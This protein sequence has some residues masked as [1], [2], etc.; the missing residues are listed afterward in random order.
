MIS[1]L[2]SLFSEKN[3]HKMNENDRYRSFFY[4][5]KVK[6]REKRNIEEVL[7]KQLSYE[8]L[9]LETLY[10]SVLCDIMEVRK[11]IS[12]QCEVYHG[13]D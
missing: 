2:H 11:P 6:L 13:N 9:I 3:P 10:N 1:L 4:Y 12:K 5:V 8:N 7:S